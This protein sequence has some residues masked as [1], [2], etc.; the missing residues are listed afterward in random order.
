MLYNYFEML[1]LYCEL[2]LDLGCAG[3]QNVSN[4][5]HP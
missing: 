3:G 4:F 2:G 5:I 1:L